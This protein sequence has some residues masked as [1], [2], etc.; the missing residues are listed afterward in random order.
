MA[1]YEI[2]TTVNV[3]RDPS[4]SITDR[5]QRTGELGALM[6]LIAEIDNVHHRATEFVKAYRQSED[7]RLRTWELTAQKIA[8]RLDAVC[9]LHRNSQLETF[10]SFGLLFKF[11]LPNL[12]VY[13][14]QLTCTTR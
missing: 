3:P 8:E 1:S 10:L 12:E 5:Y 11:E 4:N 13:E 14:V 2:T 9:S 6:K 7:K